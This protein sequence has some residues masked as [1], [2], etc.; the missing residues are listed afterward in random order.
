[1]GI[2]VMDVL[3]ARLQKSTFRVTIDTSRVKD[4]GNAEVMARAAFNTANFGTPNNHGYAWGSFTELKYADG[5]LEGKL[6]EH[7]PFLIKDVDI[8]GPI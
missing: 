7:G 3:M 2:V 4:W 5:K 6:H 1:M 8:A